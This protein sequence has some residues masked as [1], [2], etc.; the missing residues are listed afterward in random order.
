[1]RS[2]PTQFHVLQ[3]GSIELGAFRCVRQ[4]FVSVHIP[5]DRALQR[6]GAQTPATWTC[7]QLIKQ[8]TVLQV[9]IARLPALNL[10]AGGTSR[11]ADS[12]LVLLC[13]PHAMVLVHKSVPDVLHQLR[14]TFEKCRENG[15]R[16]TCLTCFGEAL[17]DIREFPSTCFVATETDDLLFNAPALDWAQVRAC[18]SRC[19]EGAFQL[20]VEPQCATDWWLQLPCHLL[21]CLGWQ[22]VATDPTEASPM[23]IS[24]ATTGQTAAV[25][26]S[27]LR[28][29]SASSSFCHRL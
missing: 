14:W 29:T 2:P 16:V 3:L 27:Q 22:A 17:S 12:D 13:T 7:P 28:R 18:Q 24:F 8:A 9:P 20:L 26:I 6:L 25:D 19:L 11:D 4:F 21:E 1:M 5:V 10:S 15:L 23:C